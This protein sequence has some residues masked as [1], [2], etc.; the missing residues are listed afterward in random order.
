MFGFKS[1]KCPPQ[2]EELKSFEDDMLQMTENVRSRKVTDQFQ[3]TLS[4]D[5]KKIK[6]ATKMLIPADKSNM[7]G[8]Q[9]I[10]NNAFISKI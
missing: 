5:I 6:N 9:N 1:R 7:A 3:T 10:H 2:I 4:K 8:H